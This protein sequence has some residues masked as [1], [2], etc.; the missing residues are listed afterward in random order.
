LAVLAASGLAA[1][2]PAQAGAREYDTKPI[3]DAR[4]LA[5]LRR[6]GRL[7]DTYRK[8]R[9]CYDLA[10]DPGAVYDHVTWR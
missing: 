8:G 9:C 7:P 6:E 2:C 3:T 1:T 10:G 4:L 5:K